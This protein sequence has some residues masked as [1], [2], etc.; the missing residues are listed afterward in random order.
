[1]KKLYLTF[2]VICG[3]LFLTGCVSVPEKT[4]TFTVPEEDVK[5]FAPEHL[6]SFFSRYNF[7]AVH[8]PNRN[9]FNIYSGVT[10]K[11]PWHYTWE[12]GK[13]KWYITATICEISPNKLIVT[14]YEFEGSQFNE[15]ISDF[16]SLLS[17]GKMNFQI[18]IQSRKLKEIAISL[19]KQYAGDPNVQEIKYIKREKTDG[20]SL[21]DGYDR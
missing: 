21:S 3:C 15:I 11:L 8:T 9:Y 18:D 1:M 14:G 17:S 19:R 12:R 13:L 7:S 20:N 5:F 6:D 16:S 2:A 10:Y 4:V